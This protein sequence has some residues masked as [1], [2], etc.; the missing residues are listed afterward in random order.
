VIGC[1]GARERALL[2]AWRTKMNRDWNRGHGAIPHLRNKGYDVRY[3]AH[4]EVRVS[5]EARKG[6]ACLRCN[7]ADSAGSQRGTTG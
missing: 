7:T 5:P 2:T 4:M 1:P 3:E 6:I